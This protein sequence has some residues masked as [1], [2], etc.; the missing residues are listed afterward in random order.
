ME[1]DALYVK[2]ALEN[3]AFDSL[4]IIYQEYPIQFTALL[5][6]LS[7]SML[8]SLSRSPRFYEM[9]FYFLMKI[10]RHFTYQESEETLKIVTNMMK[11]SNSEQNPLLY[12]TNFLNLGCQI[13]E[14]GIEIT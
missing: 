2:L 13:Y 11:S 10:L 7:T 6:D 5:K 8:T 14:L 3:D 4:F 9:K 1:F 12:A